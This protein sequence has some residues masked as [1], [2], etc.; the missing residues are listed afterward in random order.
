[1]QLNP[2]SEMHT[3]LQIN[4]YVQLIMSIMHP[5]LDTSEIEVQYMLHT[6]TIYISYT[7]FT[8]PRPQPE[9]KLILSTKFS[10]LRMFG[11]NASINWC[12]CDIVIICELKNI[13]TKYVDGFVLNMPCAI[14]PITDSPC[15]H[16]HTVS[17]EKPKG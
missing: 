6:S 1:M 11:H 5:Y 17:L 8:N 3:Y 13:E 15:L 10:M 14:K 7:V 9:D 2:Q 16:R 4:I 12:V